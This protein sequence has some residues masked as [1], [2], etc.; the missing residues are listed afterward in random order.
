MTRALLAL[1][2]A[3]ALPAAA[4]E[5]RTIVIKDA[6]VVRVDAPTLEKGTV[7]IVGGR[8]T[9]VDASAP[10]PPGAARARSST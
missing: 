4:A 10:V 6:R 8:I 2:A 1:F 9:A 3:A 5:E 7:V